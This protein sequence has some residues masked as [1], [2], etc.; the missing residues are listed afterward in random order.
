MGVFHEQRPFGPF[1][2]P[3]RSSLLRL[4]QPV[5]PVTKCSCSV[6]DPHFCP[7]VASLNRMESVLISFHK[8]CISFSLWFSC[9]AF[10]VI[11]FLSAVPNRSLATLSMI[12]VIVSIL[13][14]LPAISFWAVFCSH[15][16]SPRGMLCLFFNKSVYLSLCP[17]SAIGPSL[18]HLNKLKAKS[19]K[20]V[21]CMLQWD[22]HPSPGVPVTWVWD[23]SKGTL[24][25]STL[26]VGGLNSGPENDQCVSVM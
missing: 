11:A 17:V 9:R 12:V 25:R 3:V 23:P 19:N 14:I 15:Y 26:E 21:T 5:K 6:F 2:L 16:F 8:L 24:K 1:I 20:E 13:F 10:V 7:S 18:H 4:P 22:S